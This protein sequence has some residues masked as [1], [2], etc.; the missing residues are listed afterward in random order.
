MVGRMLSLASLALGAQAARVNRRQ[1]SNSGV[2]SIHGVP[3]INAEVAQAGPEAVRSWVLVGKAGTT[4]AQIEALCARSEACSLVGHPSAGGVPFLTVQGTQVELEKVVN[5][6][7]EVL[8]FIEPDFEASVDPP[9]ALEE[10]SGQTSLWGLDRVGV[11]SKAGTGKGVHLYIL[12]TGVRITHQDFGG[13]AVASIDVT[14]GSLVECDGSDT[15]CAADQF[16]HGTHCAGTAAGTTYGVATEATVHAVKVL[17]RYGSGDFSWC[18]EALDWIATKGSKPHVASLSLGGRGQS[19]AFGVAVR[20]AVEAGV[21]VVV[22]GGNSNTDSCGF[23]PAYVPAAI[24]V[25][26]TMSNDRRSEFSNF[27]TCTDIWAP[28]SNIVAPWYEDD[29]STYKSS[30]TSMACP[31]V[32]GAAALLLEQDAT[33]SPAEVR[34]KLLANSLPN[35]I[36]GLTTE[37]ANR[38]AYVGTEDTG[39]FCPDT[40]HGPSRGGD[41]KCNFPSKCYQNGK[42]W[43]D[44]SLTERFGRRSDTS[45]LTTCTDCECRAS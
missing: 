44:F 9:S 37:D 36:G 33:L 29:V 5:G 22:A 11:G 2:K 30:G 39:P 26:S 6:M 34:T 20:T 19:E 43:C 31:H 18:Y 12:D 38:F 24:T 13:R 3:V 27:G 40:F 28:G 1:Q 35:K 7:A 10:V 23:S 25:G 17:G 21:T 14:S 8:D 4:D 15:S 45:C 16:F 42:K 32:T 41:C